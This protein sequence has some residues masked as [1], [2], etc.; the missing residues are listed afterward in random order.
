MPE[1]LDTPRLHLRAPVQADVPAIC[2][3]LG[4]AQVRRFLGGP[5]PAAAQPLHAQAYVQQPAGTTA[6]AIQLRAGGQIVG[7]IELGPHKG[8]TDHELSYQLLPAIWGQGIA[9]EAARTV[10]DRSR[11]AAALPRVIAETQAANTRSR[12][13]LSRL[14]MAELHRLHRYGAAQV[15][16]TTHP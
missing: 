1:P 12:A 13:L 4:D 8:G 7:L 5:L 6:W 14:G 2:G 3:L 16:Y 15:I 10:L 11:A 9:T